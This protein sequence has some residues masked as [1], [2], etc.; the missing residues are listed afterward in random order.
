MQIF[1]EK[2]FGLIASSH[3]LILVERIDPV[4]KACLSVYSIQLVASS[5]KLAA[6]FQ[7]P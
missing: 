4:N 1:F 6:S 3:M 2:G 5:W 7:F